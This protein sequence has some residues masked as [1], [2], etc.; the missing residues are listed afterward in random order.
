[1]PGVLDALLQDVE[2]ALADYLLFGREMDNRIVE[3]GEL[4]LRGIVAL[5]RTQFDKAGAGI[6]NLATEIIRRTYLL[7]H[8]AAADD[9]EVARM[10]FKFLA[11][12]H[13]LARS[14]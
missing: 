14:A 13:K 1:M 8:R 11:V 12:E 3:Q 6:D 10:Q 2:V 7:N 4:P 9:G 5:R